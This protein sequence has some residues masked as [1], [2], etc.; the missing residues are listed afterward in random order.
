MIELKRASPKAIKYAC[1]HFHYARSVPSSQY[2]YNVY[3]NGEWCGVIIYST[4]ATVNIASPFGLVQGEVLELVRVALNG[5][6]SYTSQCVAASLKKL[7]ADAPQVKMIVSFAD[8]G[9]HHL[10][11]IYQATNWLYLG[12]K[13]P[14][15]GYTVVR[16]VKVHPRSLIAKYGTSSTA[17]I[18]EHVDPNAQYIP[19][20]GKHKYIFC[21]S[22]KLRREWE[23]KSLPYPKTDADK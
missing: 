20:F 17:W 13:D 22:R 14:G 12:E 18:K 15:H 19:P 23:K 8:T 10:G 5:K 4:G 7:H 3:E 1:L 16:G 11:I 21:F 2:A 9:Q 6:Q